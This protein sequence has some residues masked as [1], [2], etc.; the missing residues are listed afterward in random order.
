[1]EDLGNMVTM[2]NESVH[3]VLPHI[4]SL[5]HNAILAC[6]ASRVKS[7]SGEFEKENIPANKK[8]DHQWRF[9]A[10]VKAPGRKKQGQILYS[11]G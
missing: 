11:I 10:T 5:L 7:S 1:M 8:M 3:P 6:K 4:N 2:T 9:Q